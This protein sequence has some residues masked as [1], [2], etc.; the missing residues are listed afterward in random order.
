[1][2]KVIGFLYFCY[3]FYLFY[4]AT[5]CIYFLGN[6]FFL[7]SS[8]IQYT[9]TENSPPSTPTVSTT[10]LQA[11]FTSH[12]FPFRK[13]AGLPG[14]SNKHSLTEYNKTWQKLSNQDCVRQSSRRNGFI[15]AGTRIRGTPSPTD[16][17]PTK[18]SS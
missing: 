8:L 15:R 1:M 17:S 10:L 12:P 4:F 16:R 14:M 2:Y 6:V 5:P 11:R 9:L 3:L 13:K 7:Y 18:T